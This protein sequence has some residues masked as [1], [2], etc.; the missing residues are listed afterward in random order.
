MRDWE[1]M[2]RQRLGARSEALGD[3]VIREAAHH[4]E[5]VFE[6]SRESGLSDENSANIAWNEVRSWPR[7]AREIHRAKG[8]TTMLKDRIQRLWLPGIVPA[9]L[10][11]GVLVGF[12]T[13]G[14]KLRLQSLS[15]TYAAK[16]YYGW[17]IALPLFGA[18]SAYWSRRA[19]G[20]LP[21]RVTASLF[22]A[23]ALLSTFLI[24]FAAQLVLLPFGLGDFHRDNL[25]WG[26]FVTEVGRAG[27]TIVLLPA[28]MLFVGAIPFLRE[29]RTPEI[30]AAA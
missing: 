16:F 26:K 28:V 6:R 19:G 24:L 25:Q 7:L 10:A 27:L 21:N 13:L 3:E 20:S 22:L 11:L 14:Y 23:G 17:L 18:L 12:G 30:G 5:D 4:L 9:F 8:G 1:R 2:V 29:K 15:P